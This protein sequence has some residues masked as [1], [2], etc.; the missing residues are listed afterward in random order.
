[1]GCLLW[2]LACHFLVM[3][4]QTT[5]YAFTCLTLKWSYEYPSF[6]VV[7]QLICGSNMIICQLP[8]PENRAW[9]LLSACEIT[10]YLHVCMLSHVWLFVTPWTGACQTPLSMGFSG[11]ES[12][13]GLLC[14]PPRD[15]PDPGIEP[16]S[17]VALELQADS[18]L[19]SHGGSPVCIWACIWLYS[20]ASTYQRGI[21]IW[22]L[23]HFNSVG[24][25]FILYPFFCARHSTAAAA[26]KWGAIAFSGHS[27]GQ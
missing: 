23:Y 3:W 9:H 2:I 7:V 21:R 1:M 26:A 14:L 13:S 17:P 27:T 5:P 20:R 10:M 24:W 25:H 8:T 4:P 18:L 11:Q 15:L 19:L 22:F 12:W 16:V 6:S